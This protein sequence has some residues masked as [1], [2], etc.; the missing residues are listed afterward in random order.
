MSAEIQRVRE[1]AAQYVERGWTQGAYAR[2]ASSH[3]VAILSPRAVRFCMV[4]AI[5]RAATDLAVAEWPV[6]LA[7]MAELPPGAGLSVWNDAPDRTQAEVVAL[8]RR[9]RS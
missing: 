9:R 8:L 6:C 3:R 1:L 7:V 4:G 5:A 2:S